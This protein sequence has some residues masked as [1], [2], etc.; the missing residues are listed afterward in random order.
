MEQ[1]LNVFENCEHTSTG[2]KIVLNG[3]AVHIHFVGVAGPAGSGKDTLCAFFDHWMFRQDTQCL[4]SVSCPTMYFRKL[5][6]A[7]ALKRGCAEFFGIPL[8]NY[9]DSDKKE[10]IHPFW[11]TSPRRQAQL[12]GTEC[13]R[14]GYADDIWYKRVE[15]E[16]IKDLDLNVADSL[17]YK[18]NQKTSKAESDI[19]YHIFFFISDVRFQNEADWVHSLGGMI[20]H[21]M[22]NRE[23]ITKYTDHASENGIQ[24]DPS[25]DISI[26]N[27]STLAI[28]K[29]SCIRSFEQLFSK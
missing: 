4:M 10:E 16:M 20:F 6:F 26:D 9:Y 14:N 21:I 7:D 25:K 19:N 28:F 13:M 22:T 24:L 18:I 3:N 29:E 11:G 15:W 17:L 5:A 23:S 1:Y 12:V 2:Y 27:T 8:R